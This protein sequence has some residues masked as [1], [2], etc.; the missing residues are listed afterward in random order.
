[1]RLQLI[2]RTTLRWTLGI[3]LVPCLLYQAAIAYE[4]IMGLW[5]P[6]NNIS[7]G[8]SIG[9]P[10]PTVTGTTAVA[11]ESGMAVGDVLLEIDGKPFSGI[12]SIHSA[13][14]TRQ[15]GDSVAITV[16][17]KEGATKSFRLKLENSNINADVLMRAAL[18]IFMGVLIPVF[19]LLMGFWVAFVRPGDPL[20]WIF[21]GLTVTFGHFLMLGDG[22]GIWAPAITTLLTMFHTILQSC[23]YLFIFLFGLYFPYEW[24]QS[25]RFPW[26]KWAFI[27]GLAVTI[28]VNGAARLA[29][30]FSSGDNW[31]ITFDAKLDRPTMVFTYASISIFF[32]ALS[33]KRARSKD[34]DAKRRLR[35][36]F[37]GSMLAL[38]PIGILV[39]YSMVS[40]K[41]FD[42]LGEW[43]WVP[44]LLLL[45]LFP[46]TLAYVVVVHRAF[47][48]HVVIRQGL[49]Y[50]L[51]RGG[52]RILIA[53]LV[54]TVVIVASIRATQPG[55]RPVIVF[56]TISLG[57]A[58]SLLIFRLREKAF[59]WVDRKFFREAY[60]TEQVLSELSESVRSIVDR[61]TLLETVANRLANTLH[62]NQVA[63]LLHAEGGF[64]PAYA[65]GYSLPPEMEFL[66]TSSTVAA[67]EKQS[68]SL[69]IYFDDENNWAVREGISEAER[70][71]LLELGS[72]LILPLTV[73]N[74][75]LGFISLGAK[76]SESPYSKSDMRMLES[77]AG[78]M[79]MALE[80]S[81]LTEAVAMEAAQKER[82]NREIEIA[83]EVQQRLFPQELPPVVGLDYAGYCRPALGVGG[84]YYDFLM[85]DTG[86]VGIAIGDV[87]GKGVPA[88]LL[89]ACLQASLRGQAAAGST[90]LAKLMLNLNR[91][92]Y[93]SS[94]ANRYATFFYSQYDVETR[95]LLYSNGGHNE[96]MIVR[97]KE[98]IRL[99]VG[100]PVVGLF[101]PA[102]YEQATVQLERGDI[103]VAFT[104]GISEAMNAADDE[105]GDEC[106]A[107]TISQWGH[108]TAAEIIPKIMEAA[109]A[110]VN[111][112][113][114][115][116][117]MTITV[118]KIL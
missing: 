4:L 80:N 2:S 83:S 45:N 95:K 107:A 47:D 20:A 73:K 48:L 34:L 117:D 5:Q 32:W 103:F 56:Q 79:G 100:G 108:L 46:I 113:P 63:M 62:I 76:K 42:Q 12:T 109:D 70:Q 59:S 41:S 89:M 94:A 35:T 67:L 82:L 69:P 22:V 91:Q 21:L 3:L 7:K 118:V 9:V 97:G 116:D 16:R 92:I 68:V 19:S 27:S 75:L 99:D 104:D 114:Q 29:T 50:G 43:I 96:P 25:V 87:S 6:Q 90:D 61:K 53:L 10:W 1:M 101:R 66:G 102:R 93:D 31:W 84:D 54:L 55:A 28:V 77:V 8:F 37:F 44:C 36:L 72:N 64:R 26:F 81:R 74:R 18:V 65:V 51:M 33:E 85:L 110:F 112:A 15:H 23:F 111:G 60:A 49:Q 105:W 11:R 52:V 98:L 58:A 78:Q 86:Q 115:H 17:T 39:V 38:T 71:K 57:I 40:G 30:L 88:A 24:E 106:L 14:Q 13:L